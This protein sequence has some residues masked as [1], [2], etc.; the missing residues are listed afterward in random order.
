MGVLVTAIHEEERSFRTDASVGLI[1]G[2]NAPSPRRAVIGWA[3][4]AY[5]ILNTSEN[6]S[7]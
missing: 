1:G 5:C 6:N 7:L 3:N 2:P 4:Y